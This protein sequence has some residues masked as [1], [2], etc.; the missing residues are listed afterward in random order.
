MDTGEYRRVVGHFATGV[1]VVTTHAGGVH[2]AMTANSFTSVSLDPLLVL[3]AVERRARFHE[4][5]LAAGSFAVNV[6]AAD[7][8]DLSRWAATRGRDATDVERWAFAP[9]AATGAAVF[10]GVLAA[11]ECRTH[12]THPGGDHTLVVGEV[13][14]L[15]APRPD[16]APLLYFKGVYRALAP[17][18][19]DPAGEPLS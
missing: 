13:V 12:A 10:E 4:A 1:T 5:V 8:E 17:G 2:H 6:L 18:P 11:L 15:S 14:G 16:A 19:E 9:G 3:V 7:Q